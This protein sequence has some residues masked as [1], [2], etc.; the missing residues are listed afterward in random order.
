M[1]PILILTFA[2]IVAGC[3]TTVSLP[4]VGQLSNGATA[5]GNV[6]VDLST[7]EGSFEMFTL[8]GLSCKGK[9][10]GNNRSPTIRVPVLC[11]NGQHGVVIAT[12]DATGVA[13]TAVA[14]LQN[15]VSGRFIFGNIS[16]QQQAEFLK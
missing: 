1:K 4:V 3:A 2:V 13:G 8:A 14:Q 9:Y 15:G 6:A 16:A 7:G 12:R 11:N 10:D 5:Q